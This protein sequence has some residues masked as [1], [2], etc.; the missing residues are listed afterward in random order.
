MIFIHFHYFKEK[1][2]HDSSEILSRKKSNR[3]I[4]SNF[5]SYSLM[6]FLRPFYFVLKTNCHV[7]RKIP[8]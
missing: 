5:E 4:G 3:N 7:L 1:Q 2:Q 6:S 8:V